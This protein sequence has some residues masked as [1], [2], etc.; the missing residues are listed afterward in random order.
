MNGWIKIHR[1]ILD[2]EWYGDTNMFRLWM[3]LLL[4]ASTYDRDWMGMSI[5]RGQV[6]TTLREL[7]EETGLTTRNLRTCIERLE[8][9]KQIDKQ[10]TN[11]LSV[12]TI[13][14]YDDYQVCDDDERQTN[15]KQNDKQTTNKAK[16]EEKS[17]LNPSLK[18]KESAK[19]GK[20]EKKHTIVCKEKVA[21]EAATLI[22]KRREA[23]YQSILPYLG[24][25]TKE[26]LRGFYDYWSELNKS[27]TR[28]RWELQPTWEIGKRL[29]TWASKDNN[30]SNGNIRTNNQEGKRERD[31][32]AAS[33][34]ERLLASSSS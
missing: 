3:H 33:I 17:P 22:Q 11:K 4:K 14:K 31:I 13:C 26:M 24:K 23:F 8:N 7:E 34:V 25:Y 6:V 15:D 28:M 5:S 27:K 18:N 32:E 2:W 16:K 19:E 12:I 20:K 21:A 29:A 30:F 1:K 9:D 10:T